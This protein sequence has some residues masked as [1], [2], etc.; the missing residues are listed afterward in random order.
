M[1]KVSKEISSRLRETP[2][3]Q[4][5][6]GPIVQKLLDLGWSIDQVVFGK[7]E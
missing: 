7:R 6:V 2:E 3:Q 5:V 1:K 4:L